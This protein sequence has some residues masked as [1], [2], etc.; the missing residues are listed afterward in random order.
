MSGIFDKSSESVFGGTEFIQKYFKYDVINLLPKLQ[1]YNCL[2]FPGL[3]EK[4]FMEYSADKKQMIV[5]LHNTVYQ[6][7][8][9][10]AAAFNNIDFVN[11]IKYVIVVSE[12]AKKITLKQ[13]KLKENQIVVIYNF[14][15]PVDNDVSRFKNVDKV[16]VIHTSASDRGFDIIAHSLKY[17]DLDFRLEIYNDINPDINYVSDEYKKIYN[18]KRLFFYGKTP[19][20]TVLNAVSN[21]HIMAYPVSFQETFCL[22]HVE[23]L[24]ANCLNIF[25]DFGSLK[26]VSLGFGNL[27][28]LDF[29]NMNIEECAQF[30]A[31]ELKNGINKI[32]N[33]QFDPKNQKAI[34]DDKFSK[35]NFKNSWINFHKKI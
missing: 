15:D 4:S 9:E 25:N 14:I 33:K 23:A 12:Y 8:D 10:V 30:F 20:R 17:I 6:F 29:D 18:D 24:S 27:F 13:T 34:I 5:W 22:S 35:E 11:N 7:T 26:E 32:K 2:M 3:R 1:D 19:K 31:E 28:K 21:S 16:R